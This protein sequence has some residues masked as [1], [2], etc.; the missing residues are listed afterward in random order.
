MAVKSLAVVIFT[1]TYHEP[2][3]IV[4]AV[5]IKVVVLIMYGMGDLFKL[6]VERCKF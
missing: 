6:L 3:A 1:A 5:V 4:S 2:P